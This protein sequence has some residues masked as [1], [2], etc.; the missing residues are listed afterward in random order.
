MI[1]STAKLFKKIKHNPKRKLKISHKY[2]LSSPEISINN[3][4]KDGIGIKENPFKTI[5][6][7]EHNDNLFIKSQINELK[8]RKTLSSKLQRIDRALIK[9]ANNEKLQNN[10]INNDLLIN[11]SNSDKKINNF[12]IKNKKRSQKEINLL[13]NLFRKTNVKSTIIIDI[14][15]NN[16]LDEEQKKL[17]NDYFNKKNKNNYNKKKI[18]SFPVQKHKSDYNLFTERSPIASTNLYKKKFDKSENNLN[19]LKNINNNDK[20]LLEEYLRENKTFEEGF[21]IKDENKK[22]EI[23]GGDNNSIIEYCINKSNDSSFIDSILYDDYY[24]DLIDKIY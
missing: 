13:C 5:S 21:E 8:A 9:K 2:K 24:Q 22:E 12:D 19:G 14:Y 10:N 16:N 7:S 11:E 4:Y 15:G 18:N 23:I 17:I 6:H 1:L 3:I 20:L